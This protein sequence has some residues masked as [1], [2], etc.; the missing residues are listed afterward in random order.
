MLAGIVRRHRL[1]LREDLG[2]RL[3]VHA[4]RSTAVV[5]RLRF[6]ADVGADVNDAADRLPELAHDIECQHRT[7]LA[8][9][10][11]LDPF[12]VEARSTPQYGEVGKLPGGKYRQS[13]EKLSGNCD[14][15]TG[16]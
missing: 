12:E 1:Q 14:P 7:R 8:C 9:S 6:L 11:G 13:K 10:T 3:D 5:I 2:N 4:H 15:G 16:Q